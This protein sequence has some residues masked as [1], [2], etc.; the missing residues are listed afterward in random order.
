MSP[1]RV[2]VVGGGAAGL[3]TAYLLRGRHEVTVFESTERL[4]GNICTLNVNVPCND[5]D[6]QLVLDAGVIEFDE[7]HFATFRCL[8]DELGVERLQAP[9]TTAVYFEDG[10]CLRSPGNIAGGSSG[11]TERLR[12]YLDLIPIT[13]AQRRFQKRVQTIC[14]DDAYRQPIENLLE[15]GDHSKWL[16]MLLMYAYS[17]DYGDT[18]AIPAALAAPMLSKFT[19][20]NDWT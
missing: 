10:R 13:L 2:C 6:D 8:L 3:V 17:I 20:H 11:F 1:L 12:A 19:R 15:R 18:K 5:L 16:R 7:N 9:G 14:P 4:G